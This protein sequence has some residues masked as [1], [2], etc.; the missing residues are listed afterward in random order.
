MIKRTW[1]SAHVPVAVIGNFA[2]CIRQR[3]AR[4]D[5]DG[6]CRRFLFI[7]VSPSLRARV[8]ELQLS[9]NDLSVVCFHLSMFY[10]L[11]LGLE[12]SAAPHCRA[13]RTQLLVKYSES[14]GRAVCSHHRQTLSLCV[15]RNY[16]IAQEISKS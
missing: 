6:I 14:G 16:A 10:I 4:I 2:L 5:C 13:V 15:A 9:A 12:L 11:Y 3:R 1:L 7:F 8:F